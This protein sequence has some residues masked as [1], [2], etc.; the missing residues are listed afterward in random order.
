MRPREYN[1]TAWR[2]R[3][4]HTHTRQRGSPLLLL[5]LLSRAWSACVCVS[6]RPRAHFRS[7]NVAVC[8]YV[9]ACIST[10]PF[11]AYWAWGCCKMVRMN[12]APYFVGGRGVYPK[13]PVIASARAHEHTHARIPHSFAWRL[14]SGIMGAIWRVGGMRALEPVV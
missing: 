3:L 7:V 9:V 2:A 13:I 14:H 10:N 8:L 12:C 4:T 11:A 5:L 6:G 1:K